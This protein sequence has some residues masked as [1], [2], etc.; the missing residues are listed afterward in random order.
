MIAHNTAGYFGRK[1]I[2]VFFTTSCIDEATVAG[3]TCTSK[4]N[5]LNIYTWKLLSNK[6]KTAIYEAS[7]SL[8][9]PIAMSYIMNGLKN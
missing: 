5:T 8:A 6:A 2:G 3:E 7:F 1:M 4:N 9:D